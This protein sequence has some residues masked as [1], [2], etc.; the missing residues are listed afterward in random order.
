LPQT[1]I[2]DLPFE[3]LHAILDLLEDQRAIYPCLFVDRKLS[4]VAQM[5]LLRRVVLRSSAD[6]RLFALYILARSGLQDRVTH[7][8]CETQT[9]SIFEVKTTDIVGVETQA[10][11]LSLLL[12]VLLALRGLESLHLNRALTTQC[13]DVVAAIGQLK[14]LEELGTLVPVG[15]SHLPSSGAFTWAHIARILR[16]TPNIKSIALGDLT[17]E[18]QVFSLPASIRAVKIGRLHRRLNTEDFVTLL[19][20]LPVTAGSGLT[21]LKIRS[22]SITLHSLVVIKHYGANISCLELAFNAEH[23]WDH[24]RYAWQPNYFQGFS[25]R[26]N[27]TL[28]HQFANSQLLGTLLPN[29]LSSL[30]LGKSPLNPAWIIVAALRQSQGRDFSLRLEA[31]EGWCTDHSECL[32]ASE[33]GCSR[34]WF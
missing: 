29:S 16:T 34:I 18:P 30:T 7:L 20:R 25:K 26:R 11:H 31:M 17:D 21:S 14:R 6:L 3:V 9:A 23:D 10:S 19:S 13:E 8:H 32:Q 15:R 27:L 12:P 33:S 2:T 24:N 28:H 4:A 5:A 1:S 22:S